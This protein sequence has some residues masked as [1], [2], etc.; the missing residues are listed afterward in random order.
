MPPRR[1]K[2]KFKEQNMKMINSNVQIWFPTKENNLLK[3]N[4]QPKKKSKLKE[5]GSIIKFLMN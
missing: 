4:L 2:L 1:R 3:K 5:N